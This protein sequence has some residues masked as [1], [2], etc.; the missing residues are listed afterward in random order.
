MTFVYEF[1]AAVTLYYKC[2]RQSFQI[3]GTKSGSALT[4]QENDTPTAPTPDIRAIAERRPSTVYRDGGCLV[5]TNRMAVLVL[6]AI[7]K[8]LRDEAN[9]T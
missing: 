1:I 8:Q 5:N 9:Q 3:T 6:L 2:T 7:A 4:G